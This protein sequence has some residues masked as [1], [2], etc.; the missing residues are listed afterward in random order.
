[1]TVSHEPPDY[2]CPFCGILR[3]V[4]HAKM[5]T[6]PEEVV[7]RGDGV[8]AFISRDQWPNNPGHVLV[9]PEAHIENLYA[10]PDELAVALQ[11]ATRRLALAL[12]RAYDCPGTSTRQHN[13]PAGNQDVWHYHIHVFPRFHDDD[14]YGSRPRALTRETRLQQ[15]ATLRAA[16]ALVDR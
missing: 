13:E 11:S 2:A 5:A 12:K 1:M 10:L 15:A 3:C 7:L 9:V 14:L 6:Q 4:P 16:L 8:A